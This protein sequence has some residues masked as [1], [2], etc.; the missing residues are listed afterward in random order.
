MLPPAT[1]TDR[2]ARQAENA[3]LPVL[4]LFFNGRSGAR[5]PTVILDDQ[6]R[7]QDLPLPPQDGGDKDCACE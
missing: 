4:D 3:D 5:T 2:A 6:A 7:L 1:E